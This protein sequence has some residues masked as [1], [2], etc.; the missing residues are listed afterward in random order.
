MRHEAKEAGALFLIAKPFTAATFQTA[1]DP[2]LR[3]RFDG[4]AGAKANYDQNL[5]AQF[6]DAAARAQGAEGSKS[7]WDPSIPASDVYRVLAMEIVQKSITDLVGRPCVAKKDASPMLINA[8]KSLAFYRLDGI[9]TVG[10]ILC[11]LPLGAA[12]SC[13]LSVVPPNA[14]KEAIKTGKLTDVQASN[15]YEVFNVLSTA[16]D[17]ERGPHLKLSK[18][19]SPGEPVPKEY[20]MAIIK[21]KARLD[22]VIDVTGYGAGKMSFIASATP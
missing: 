6:S 2:Y 10:F 17:P 15:L 3:D 7:K 22:L 20:M 11:D 4:G 21:P 9:K 1:L 8:P 14:V 16:F 5:D 13:A 12:A 18:V 19:F